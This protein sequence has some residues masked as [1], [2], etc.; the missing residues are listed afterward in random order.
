MNRSLASK[1]V[2]LQAWRTESLESI[3]KH[4]SEHIYPGGRLDMPLGH[5]KVTFQMVSWAAYRE[6]IHSKANALAILVNN[7]LEKKSGGSE[8]EIASLV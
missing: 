8:I 4:T 6:G 3:N 1:L 2:Q 7:L 5:R